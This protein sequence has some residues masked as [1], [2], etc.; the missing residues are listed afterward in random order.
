MNGY[1]LLKYMDS[2]KIKNMLKNR[3]I[4]SIFKM[5]ALFNQ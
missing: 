4:L 5:M 3:Q 1:G 2:L